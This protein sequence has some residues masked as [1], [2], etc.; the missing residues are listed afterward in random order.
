L[1]ASYAQWELRNIVTQNQTK[2][3]VKLE[4]FYNTVINL[5]RKYSYTVWRKTASSLHG[6]GTG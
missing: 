4:V 3:F 1:T 6:F 5:W 2:N